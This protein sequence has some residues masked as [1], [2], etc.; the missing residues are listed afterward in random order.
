MDEWIDRW[1]RVVLIIHDTKKI[2][3]RFHWVKNFDPVR[4]LEWVHSGMTHSDMRNSEVSCKQM[5]RFEWNR[6]EVVPEWISI[7][8]HSQGEAWLSE[9]LACEAASLGSFQYCPSQKVSS[10]RMTFNNGQGYHCPWKSWKVLELGKNFFIYLQKIIKICFL[11]KYF[12]YD[13]AVKQRLRKAWF[14]CP[15]IP[16]IGRFSLSGFVISVNPNKACFEKNL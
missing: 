10:Y 12:W 4:K 9:Y 2:A 11:L 3:I 13:S 1:T 6:H 7:C 5:Q 14:F 15:K 16:V 8:K